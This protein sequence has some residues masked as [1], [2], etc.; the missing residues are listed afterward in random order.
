MYT[1]LIDVSRQEII[2]K[3]YVLVD[4]LEI[5]DLLLAQLPEGDSARHKDGGRLGNAKHLPAKALEEVGDLR[6]KG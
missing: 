2:E 1:I 6:K 5:H 4:H 3:Q